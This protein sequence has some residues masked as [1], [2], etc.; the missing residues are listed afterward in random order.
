MRIAAFATVL[1]L[2]VAPVA[3]AG[4]QVVVDVEIGSFLSEL[5]EVLMVIPTIID[6]AATTNDTASATDDANAPI[7]PPEGDAGPMVIVNG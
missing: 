7:E 6:K 4:D 5:W 1:C 3:Y 2:L